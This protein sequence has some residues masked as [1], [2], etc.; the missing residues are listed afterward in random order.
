MMY[1]E[2][3][4]RIQPFY[5]DDDGHGDQ[6][7]RR[8]KKRTDAGQTRM[9]T[10]DRDALRW[11]GE[12]MVIRFDQLQRLLARWSTRAEKR[13]MLAK[14][15]TR[16][17]IRRWAQR[18]YVVAK[19][20]N[21]SVWIWLTVFGQ[22]EA[23]LPYRKPFSGRTKDLDHY[24]YTN[25]VRLDL[26]DAYAE[27]NEPFAWTSQRE[28]VRLRMKAGASHYADGLARSGELVAAVE[29]ELTPKNSTESHEDLLALAQTYNHVWFYV[30]RRTKTNVANRLK[31]LEP[32]M[33]QAFTVIEL[34][35]T[36]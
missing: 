24:F 12:M 13:E 15:S 27:D 7:P 20:L 32:T 26:E 6:G 21:G 30:S 16:D 29:V 36:A 1:S 33:Q 5:T 8:R 17:V 22:E 4:R 19:Q 23:Q 34:E 25:Q 35:D 28:L 2:L 9:T 3:V 18:G 10:R 14:T 11:I 31:R